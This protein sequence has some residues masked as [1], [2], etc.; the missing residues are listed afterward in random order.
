MPFCDL[1]I[2]SSRSDGTCSPKEIARL[3]KKSGLCAAALTDHHTVRGVPDFLSEAKKLKIEA[4]PG[5]EI[6]AEYQGKE[7]HILG[8]YLPEKNLS[9]IETW[10]NERRQRKREKYIALAE[11]LQKAGYPICFEDLQKRFPHS[12]INRA[13]FGAFLTEKG[14]TSST[15]EA[16]RT[17]LHEKNGFYTPPPRPY[18]RDVIEKIRNFGGIA[19]LAHPLLNIPKEMLEEY[20]TQAKACG[21]CAAETRYSLYTEND[22]KTVAMLAKK[23]GLLESGGSDFHGEIKPTISLGTGTG[24]L[25][26]PYAFAEK[27]KHAAATATS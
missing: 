24:N 17:V 7:V 4:I 14:I 15:A 22:E 25:R 6:A 26:V 19:V 1:H 8:L 13:H 3:A 21:A 18:Y 5:I 27:L 16:L 9:A 12:E 20:F 10:M 2:H 23:T 11:N